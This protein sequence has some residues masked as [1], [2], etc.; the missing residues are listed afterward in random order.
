MNRIEAIQEIL[1]KH[2]GAAF[3]F[4][5]GLNSRETNFF[6]DR[7]SNLYLLHSMGEALSVGYGLKTALLDRDVVVID[8]DGNAL[9][10]MASWSVLPL[11]GLHY[12][13]L[14]NEVYE[15]TGGQPLP[16]LPFNE[17]VKTIKI[18]RGKSSTPN[19]MLPE[20]IVKRFQKWL[21]NK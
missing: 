20:L 2:I 19:P 14:C 17:H 1:D 12:Y 5:N 16:K 13:V 11:Q 21:K 3:V 9:M 10:G 6:L 7:D 8:G 4:C 18:D 15:T